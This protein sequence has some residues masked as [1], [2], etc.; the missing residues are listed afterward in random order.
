MSNYRKYLAQ[1]QSDMLGRNVRSLTGDEV[2]ALSAEAAR[3]GMPL[4][5]Y[6]QNTASQNPETLPVSPVSKRTN[7]SGKPYGGAGT[8]TVKISRLGATTGAVLPVVIG[9]PSAGAN[10]Y[11]GVFTEPNT[12][13]LRALVGGSVRDG[14]PSLAAAT[15]FGNPAF[16]AVD[17]SINTRAIDDALGFVYGNGTTSDTIKITCS[18]NISYIEL[19]EKLRSGYLKYNTVKMKVPAANTDQFDQQIVSV[20]RNIMGLQSDNAFTPGTFVDVNQQISNLVEIPLSGTLNDDNG[21]IVNVNAV[22]QEISL[23]FSVWDFSLALG[24]DA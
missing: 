4:E 14:R 3:M 21:L 1:V 12:Y 2:A 16:P 7:P 10:N 9:M 13:T 11:K 5:R 19:L 18:D 17:S 8:I 24:S 15:T 23:I 20:S 6:L 22:V